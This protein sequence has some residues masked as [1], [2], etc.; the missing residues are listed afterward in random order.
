MFLTCSLP[1]HQN[2]LSYTDQ[3]ARSKSFTSYQRV[4]W[5]VHVASEQNKIEQA[6][7]VFHYHSFHVSL[8][9]YTAVVVYS[10]SL[11]VFLML[12][13]WLC[14]HSHF[15]IG[16]PLP[17]RIAIHIFAIADP[18]FLLSFSSCIVSTFWHDGNNGCAEQR[19]T[20]KGKENWSEMEFTVH[21]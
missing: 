7:Q 16:W 3:K 5:I 9:L 1:T 17:M 14:H 15:L 11:I 21:E 6:Q 18:M 13:G 19:K 20:R 10:H 8:L 12:V 4:Q 2:L